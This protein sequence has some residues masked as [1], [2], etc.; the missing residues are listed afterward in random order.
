MTQEQAHQVGEFIREARDRLAMS[1]RDLASRCGVHAT[2]IRKIEQGQIAQ[3]SPQVLQRI[4][5]AIGCDYEDLA[6]LAGVSLPEGLPTLPVYLRTKY[7]LSQD[8]IR[9]V[10]GYVRYLR[11]Q[12]EHEADDDAQPAR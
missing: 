11:E 1:L 7:E 8:E 9:Q 6:A 4:A 3:P 10:D 2:T 12:H 5:R